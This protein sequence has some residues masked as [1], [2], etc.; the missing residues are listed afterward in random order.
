M[1]QEDRA[2]NAK[3]AIRVLLADDHRLMRE[4]MR[5][6]IGKLPGAEVVAEAEDGSVAVQLARELLPD[7]AILD[8]SMPTLGGIE[9]TR[10]IV[11]EA[12]EVKVLGV[13]VHTDRRFVE[14]MLGAGASGF[15]LK[16][17]AFE[18]LPD[19][20]RVVMSGGVY[21]SPAVVD[22]VEEACIREEPPAYP[23]APS[24]LAEQEREVLKL[25]VV[26]LSTEDI[27]AR[28]CVEL[29]AVGRLR[30]QV[31]SKVGIYTM[32]GLTRYARQQGLLGSDS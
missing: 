31:M 32:A 11:S 9:A 27:A 6:L 28:L 23:A 3:K 2:V 15:L 18:E 5:G 1:S 7:L 19:A 20:V 29:R 10:R 26:G 4:G 22:Q 12:P 24:V 13:S 8:V 21:L 16:D 30:R 17:A 14:E 25:L